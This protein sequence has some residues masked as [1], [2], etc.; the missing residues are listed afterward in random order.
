[1]H[2][3]GQRARPL[4]LFVITQ[5]HRT[6][7][8]CC[9]P[10][11]ALCA[12]CLCC[13]AE[14]L[15]VSL[16]ARRGSHGSHGAHGAGA[17]DRGSAVSHREHREH[18][19]WARRT[20][21]ALCSLCSLCEIEQPGAERKR[22]VLR[23]LRVRPTSQAFQQSMSLCDQLR[24]RT[25]TQPLPRARQFSTGQ[26]RSGPLSLSGRWGSRMAAVTCRAAAS[27]NARPLRRSHSRRRDAVGDH[28]ERFALASHRPPAD[29]R[30]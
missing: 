14:S 13:S 22:R 10:S 19:A 23:V 20:A 3:T 17:F 15:G 4:W 7:S 24:A 9:S 2:R 21:Q 30:A 25:P 5:R 27:S 18:R 26:V 12:L 16:V 28:G 29:T 11:R 1:V 8:R 6:Q